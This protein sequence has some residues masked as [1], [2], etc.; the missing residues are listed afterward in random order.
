MSFTLL[1]QV[2]SEACSNGAQQQ[3]LKHSK[4]V[5]AFQLIENEHSDVPL[6]ITEIM[7]KLKLCS[8]GRTVSRCLSEALLAYNY[9]TA[10]FLLSSS[11]QHSSKHECLPEAVF[12]SCTTTGVP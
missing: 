4:Q 11:K 7:T 10:R 6:H 9:E 12:F 3:Q 5:D 1:E 8:S 2:S